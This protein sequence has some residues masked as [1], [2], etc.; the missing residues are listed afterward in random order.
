MCFEMLGPALVTALQST[1]FSNLTQFIIVLFEDCN[2]SRFSE[3]KKISA[4]YRTQETVKHP[5]I[6]TFP[7]PSQLMLF[8]LLPCEL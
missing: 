8:L 1:H 4:K 7:L 2:F 5:A 3:E 6:F